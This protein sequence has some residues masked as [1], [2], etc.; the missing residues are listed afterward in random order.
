MKPFN[1]EQAKQGKKVVT[2]DGQE[3]KQFTVFDGVSSSYVSVWG[4]V[5][6]AVRGWLENGRFLSANQDHHLDLFMATE[7]KTMYI[8][9]ADDNTGNRFNLRLTSNAYCSENELKEQAG[10]GVVMSGKH[11]IVSFEIEV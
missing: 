8:A 5:G 3:V 10:R 1:L 6:G 2:R 9:V 7:K 4:V 11:Q